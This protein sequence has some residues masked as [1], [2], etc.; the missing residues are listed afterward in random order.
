MTASSLFYGKRRRL[1]SIRDALA[2]MERRHDPFQMRA[3][4]GGMDYE[5]PANLGLT[6]MYPSYPQDMTG[7]PFPHFT[8]VSELIPPNT[9]YDQRVASVLQVYE[10]WKSEADTLVLESLSGPEDLG[11]FQVIDWY[12]YLNQWDG[13]TLGGP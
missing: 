4:N 9:Y 13:R 7:Y 5:V 2:K 8:K 12:L 3:P 11:F 10:A 6:L 1:E